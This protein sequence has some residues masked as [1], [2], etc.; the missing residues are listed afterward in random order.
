YLIRVD[1]EH[2]F[3]PPMRDE[4]ARRRSAVT[5]HEHTVAVAQGDDRG[6]VG[7]IGQRPRRNFEEVTDAMEETEETGPR[8]VTGGKQRNVHVRGGYRLLAA[9]LDVTLHE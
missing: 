5:G 8:V 6:A 2:L 7:N 9:L 4:V 1:R 3:H